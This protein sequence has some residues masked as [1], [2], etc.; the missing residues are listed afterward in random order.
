LLAFVTLSSLNVVNLGKI[1][2]K[3]AK[4]LRE[5]ARE[6]SKVSW[7]LLRKVRA[8]AEEERGRLTQS[9]QWAE[10]KEAEARARSEELGRQVV[11]LE[12]RL[13]TDANLLRNAQQL[14]AEVMAKLE[15]RLQHEEAA[16]LELSQAMDQLKARINLLQSSSSSSIHNYSTTNNQQ[17]QQPQPQQQQQQQQQQSQQQQPQSQQQQTQPQQQQQ[18]Q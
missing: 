9:V 13:R 1:C 4:E 7:E 18:Q 2:G 12:A 15:Q 14:H 17:Q 11:E 5:K 6:D 16:V 3:Q 10:R 8:Q